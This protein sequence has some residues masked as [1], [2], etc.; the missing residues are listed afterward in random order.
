MHILCLAMKLMGIYDPLQRQMARNTYTYQPLI[1][2]DAKSTML[3]LF[4]NWHPCPHFSIF[5]LVQMHILE[6]IKNILRITLASL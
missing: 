4:L 5:S 2:R 1:S 3:S 6:W